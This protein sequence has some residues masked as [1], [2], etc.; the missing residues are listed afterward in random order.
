M[1]VAPSPAG[2]AR[3]DALELQAAEFA[4]LKQ[5]VADL[6]AGRETAAFEETGLPMVEL[7]GL[8]ADDCRRRSPVA[9]LGDLM[10]DEH[11]WGT[12]ARISPEAPVMV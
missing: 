9:V 2:A 7:R 11:I 4:L 1:S 3:I 12:V 6:K 8:T 10:L 5:Q